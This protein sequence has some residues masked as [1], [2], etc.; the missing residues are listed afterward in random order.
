MG[1]SLLQEAITRLEKKNKIIIPGIYVYETGESIQP[2][3]GSRWAPSQYRSS[4][5]N[6][7]F[8]KY[9]W[10]INDSV[11]Q[12]PLVAWEQMTGGH[13]AVHHAGP[14]SYYALNGAWCLNTMI[15]SF[16]YTQQD[17][18]ENETYYQMGYF[19][20]FLIGKDQVVIIGDLEGAYDAHHSIVDRV[21]GPL[22]MLNA[23]VSIQNGDN[24]FT[25]VH[26]LLLLLAF[27]YISYHSFF[28]DRIGEV[29]AQN[30]RIAW[31]L[32]TLR[33]RMNLIVIFLLALVFMLFF[34]FYIH[35][36]ILLTYFG[37]AE[38]LLYQYRHFREKRRR[39]LEN[40]N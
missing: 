31:I 23:L 40:R 14:F 34:H 22:A 20:E 33:A 38:F 28:K 13:M 1:D 19:S 32:R 7:Q 26:L 30:R 37:L 35:L 11:K 15:P 25:W 4:F 24:V 9:T 2:Y 27:L 16:R 17:L 3:F 8:L 36:L 21:P 12:M 39:K 6:D 29:Y 10:I 5:M 18:V